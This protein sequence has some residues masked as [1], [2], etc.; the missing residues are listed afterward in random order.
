MQSSYD[1]VS[2]SISLT[3]ISTETLAKMI[4]QL[5]P[6]TLEFLQEI[7]TK[8]SSTPYSLWSNSQTYGMTET[9]CFLNLL[10]AVLER[11]APKVESS[12]THTGMT[13]RSSRMSSSRL[14]E[15]RASSAMLTSYR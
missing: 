3:A 10:S 9:Q 4:K 14:T 13:S 15:S 11:N 2:L 6:E 7:N 8:C 5:L 1:I 12:V